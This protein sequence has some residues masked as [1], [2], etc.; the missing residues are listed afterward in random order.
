MEHARPRVLAGALRGDR[1]RAG[2]HSEPGGLRTGRG[3]ARVS[4]F[5]HTLRRQ[6]IRIGNP[7]E[8]GSHGTRLL[9]N[10]LVQPG[11]ERRHLLDTLLL[12]PADSGHLS[13]RPPADSAVEGNVSDIHIQRAGHGS[14]RQTG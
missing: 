13:G 7:A 6:R 2:Q 11:R 9:H 3:T 12:R 14:D 4:G 10:I 1:H 5:R 8:K